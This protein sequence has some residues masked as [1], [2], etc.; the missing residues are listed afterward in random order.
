VQFV[1]EQRVVGDLKTLHLMG[2]QFVFPPL[3]P[4]G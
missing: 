1:G 2:F 4:F 3:V